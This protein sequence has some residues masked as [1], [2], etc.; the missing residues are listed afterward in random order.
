M[1]I[2]II[3]NEINTANEL[4]RILVDLDASNIIIA[5]LDSVEESV[6]FLRGNDLPDLIFS[7]IQLADGM[8]FD[9]FREVPIKT[10]II[11]C[12]SFDEY[13]LDAF[14]TNAVSYLLK[15]ITKDSVRT[16]ME[17]YQTLK[18]VF[19]SAAATLTIEKLGQQLKN[20]YKKSILVEQRESIIPLPVNDIAYI[21]LEN[22]IVQIGTAK[23]HQYFISSTLDE[24][25]RMLD[26]E[27]FYRANRQFIINKLSI[28]NVEKIFPRKLLAKLAVNTPESI[29][30]SKANASSFLRWL[31]GL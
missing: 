18:S 10:P 8:C 28:V 30:I 16:A 9:I 6:K 21:Y 22:T 4:K 15:P 24:L 19:E 5:I 23:N 27:V 1:R 25:E 7:D 12:T 11:F 31:E 13:M 3:E 29:V 26:P 17:K 2:L 20:N 14:K